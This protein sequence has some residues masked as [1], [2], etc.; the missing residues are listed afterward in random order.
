[1]IQELLKYVCTNLEKNK[2]EYMVSGSLA[3]ISYTIPRMTR[4]IDIVINLNNNNL[5]A[6]KG[7]FKN[8]FYYNDDTIKTELYR[9]GMFNVIDHET[10]FKIDFI[11]RKNTEYRIEE[12]ERKQRTV[13]FGFPCYIVS[14]EDLII[15]KL[16]W[17]Q[18]FQSNTQIEDIKN[19]INENIDMA[20]IRSWIGKLKIETFDLL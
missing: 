20:Y 9:K 6:F 13:D 18:D 5:D 15:S 8:R 16:I 2:I 3:L 7:I 14:K 19:L 10:G 17:I 4:D 1:M 12:F 11:I